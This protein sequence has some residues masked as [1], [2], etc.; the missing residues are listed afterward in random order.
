MFKLLRKLS[1]FLGVLLLCSAPLLG[2]HFGIHLGLASILDNGFTQSDVSVDQGLTF[3]KYESETTSTYTSVADFN[4][5]SISSNNFEAGE[6][7]LLA[8]ADTDDYLGLNLYGSN[9]FNSSNPDW[10]DADADSSTKYEYRYRKCFTL[11]HTA[12][13]A[14]TQSD[15]QLYLQFDTATAVSEGKMNANGDDI[16]F[17][18]STGTV[19]DYLIADDMNTANTRVW[20][21]MDSITAAATETI[22]MYYGFTAG[23]PTAATSAENTFDYPSSEDIYT[24]LHSNG[25]GATYDASSYFAGNQLSYD[26]ETVDLEAYQTASFPLGV[27]QSTIISA[28]GPIGGAFNGDESDAI[29]PL[30]AAGTEFV[31]RI[32]RARNSFSFFSPWCA[33]DV[34]VRNEEDNIITGGDF[35][36]AVGGTYDFQSTNNGATGLPNNDVVMV[37]V[38]NGCPILVSH[39]TQNGD[40]FVMWPA[41]TEWY[42]VASRELEIG[43]NTDGTNV[44]I[45]EDDG[46]TTP[47]VLNRGQ[48]TVL[49]DAADGAGS[50]VRITS[51]Q[52]I[53]ALMRND[54]DGTESVTLLPASELSSIYFV[55]QDSQYVTIATL[56]GVSTTVDYYDDGS[57]CG[58]GAPDGTSTVTPA[59]GEPGK[60]FFGTTGESS[61]ISEGACFVGDRPFFAHFE[62]RDASAFSDETNMWGA[63]QSRQYIHPEPTNTVS[64]PETGSY[65]LDGSDTWSRRIPVPITNNSTT[66]AINEYTYRI[67]MTAPDFANLFTN[68]QT[69]G[70]DIRVAGS[71]GDGTDDIVYWLE[72]YDSTGSTGTLWVQ[73]SSA[74]SSSETVYIYYDSLTVLATTGSE[75]SAFSYT[76]ERELF[77]IVNNSWRSQ[78]IDLV[79]FI[80]SNNISI[81]NN[82]YAL[83]EGGTITTA[84]STT[85]LAQNSQLG[86][87]GPIN[88]TSETDGTDVLAPVSYY[89]TQ[90]STI[91][92]R[93]AEN[94]SFYAPFGTANVSVFSETGGGTYSLNSS[95]VV[96]GGTFNNIATT[97]PNNDGVLITSDAPILAALR[98]GNNDGRVLYPDLEAFEPSTGNYELWGV[99]SDIVGIAA[100]T[101]G[102]TNVTVYRSDAPGGTPVVLN[103][104]NDYAAQING[105][106]TGGDGVAIR[107]VSD[108]PVSTMQIRDRDGAESSV[109]LPKKE[110]HDTYVLGTEA[111]YFAVAA[112]DASV[113]CRVYDP[114]GVEITS[115]DAAMDNVPPQTTGANAAP[116][117]NFL[118]IGGN[119]NGDAAFFPSG[120]YMQC[121]APV[122]AHADIF[123]GEEVNFLTVPQGRKRAEV[124]PTTTDIDLSTEEGLY[125][126]SGFDS[127]G[128]GSDP[129]ATIDFEIDLSAIANG[130]HTYFKQV[131]WTEI[132]S[133]RTQENGV[134]PV[135]IQ[136]AYADSGGGACSAVVYSAYSSVVETETSN[137]VDGT[138]PYSTETTR[139]M[140]GAI[141]DSFSDHDCF[142]VRAILRTGDEAYTPKITQLSLAYSVPS[143]MNDVLNAPTI[144]I[145][146]NTSGATER[147][148]VMKVLTGNAGL[149]GS[150]SRMRFESVS[151]GSV[152]TNADF[153]FYEI[154]D[155]TV[156]SQF[157]YPPFP[158]ASVE[159]ALEADFDN[160]N[161]VALYFDHDRS[162]GATQSID[163]TF[164]CDILDS[165]QLRIERPFQLDIGG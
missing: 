88:A 149:A 82:D 49:T 143:A 1:L 77:A 37:E 14:V 36:L 103:A 87:L 12:A 161:A 122:M 72:D 74:A 29:H 78:D 132:I 135:E 31:Y 139:V 107:V 115:G 156:I 56:E 55:P 45:V 106:G 127:A 24:V 130:E 137:S 44:T 80:D 15:Y 140:T 19:L 65:G 86:V 151:D 150:K 64:A 101:S 7:D 133:D 162:A 52:P 131:N 35:S 138:P 108:Q 83:N 113:T 98:G 164:V 4:A 116:Q 18:D 60:I 53:G 17:V 125:Y 154:A 63:K 85:P 70:G 81:L 159:A 69:D 110:W 73:T 22:C 13:S 124:E 153:E 48:E 11:D 84:I 126:E 96:T 42:G 30:S 91:A 119:D 152:F 46:T 95:V 158:G 109:F 123:D 147:S 20:L 2:A 136:I 40:T 9:A 105:L 26:S 33:A 165:G 79:S 47:V 61:T 76:A 57:T 114:S 3:L 148:R 39:Y 134:N 68:A 97:I 6:Q 59:A 144:T 104:A 38:T 21:Q 25:V 117:P 94:F 67:D 163:L 129:E 8:V 75:L 118:H 66:T 43:A 102:T 112:E 51:D 16:R 58:V 34:E 41:D 5:E 142:R 93:G 145:A 141:P 160:S 62:F 28:L 120:Y 157:D 27:E 128:A 155:Q 90:F 146:G 89:G 50:A 23:V 10:W 100:S 54:S 99:G 32:D 111:K 121:S 71:A 92:Y